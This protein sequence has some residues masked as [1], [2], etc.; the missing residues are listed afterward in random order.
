MGVKASYASWVNGFELIG[1]KNREPTTQDSL[2]KTSFIS[3]RTGP[4]SLAA[5][6]TFARLTGARAGET[7][8]AHRPAPY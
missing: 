8:S 7:R 3:Q 5:K 6:S 1:L 4:I 2:L